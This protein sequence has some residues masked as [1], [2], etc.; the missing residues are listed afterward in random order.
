VPY[1][2]RSCNTAVCL[3]L[4][5]PSW[6]PRMRDP[7]RSVCSCSPASLFWTPRILC[8]NEGLPGGCAPDGPAKCSRVLGRLCF[9]TFLR[10]T[11]LEWLLQTPCSYAGYLGVS[12]LH[13]FK[14]DIVSPASSA[15]GPRHRNFSYDVIDNFFIRRTSQYLTGYRRILGI[16]D[17]RP[18]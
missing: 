18:L 7:L 2:P 15:N 12:T 10:S 11:C 3:R 6:A 16:I 8:R 13:T 1:I 14:I 4:Y 17:L 5:Q 9:E